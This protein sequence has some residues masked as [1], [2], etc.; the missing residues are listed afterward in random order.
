MKT[1]TG[2][3]FRRHRDELSLKLA[4]KLA[5]KWYPNNPEKVEQAA[6]RL[7]DNRKPCSCSMCGNPRRSKT[8]SGKEKLTVQERKVEITQREHIKFL[9]TCSNLP[10]NI[11]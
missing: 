8:V 5:E 3:A 9:S 7:K 10:P 4:H 11:K 6:R 2:R 1:K